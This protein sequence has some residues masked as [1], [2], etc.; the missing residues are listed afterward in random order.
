MQKM[1]YDLIFLKHITKICTLYLYI[2]IIIFNHALN[3]MHR[4]KIL[5]VVMTYLMA[6]VEESN[7]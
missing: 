6:G 2:Y 5:A 1:I 3:C 4:E 7:E